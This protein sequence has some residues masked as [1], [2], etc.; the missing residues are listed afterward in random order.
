MKNQG[1]FELV[2]RFRVALAMLSFSQLTTE[3]EQ[4]AQK[5]YLSQDGVVAPNFRSQ[6]K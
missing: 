3:I 5:Q 1:P 4:G 2:L 6:K